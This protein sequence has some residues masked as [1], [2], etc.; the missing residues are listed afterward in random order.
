MNVSILLS[1]IVA[2]MYYAAGDFIGE[3]SESMLCRLEDMAV[4]NTGLLMVMFHGD[5]L[6][7]R[8]IEIIDRVVE[9]GL[10]NYWISEILNNHKILSRKIAFLHPLDG[11]Y[12][13]NQCHM[14]PAFYHLL[15]GWCLSAL[16][17]MVE[18][19]YNR[20]LSKNL[21][22]FSGCDSTLFL[23]MSVVTQNY[24]TYSSS[25]NSLASSEPVN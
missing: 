8:V 19:F 16:C 14:Q 11:Y 4:F 23:S 1:D 24:V 15:M 3:N 22:L 18:T 20:I 9:A 13:F 17:F 25:V 5:L 12:S 10:Y 6:L 7:R 21:Q 2:E